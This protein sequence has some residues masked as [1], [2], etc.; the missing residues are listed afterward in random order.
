MK[1]IAKDENN[2]K[3]FSDIAEGDVVMLPAFGATLEEMRELDA[4]NVKVVDTTCPWVA[5]VW[6]TGHTHQVRGLTSIIHG[7]YAHEETIA[8][9]SMC[10]TYICVKNE[11]EAQLVVD[12][13]LLQ[14]DLEAAGTPEAEAQLDEAAAELMKTFQVAASSHFDPKTHL[15]RVGLANQ[16]TMYK[17]ET[18]AIGQM[19]Q[20]TMMKVHGPDKIND[21]Y[22]EFDTICS[23]T[24][25]R[26][27]AVDALCDTHDKVRKS[28]SCERASE[29]VWW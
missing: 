10:E 23:A 26:Q 4:K 14:K 13:M 27:D 7:K 21:H 28:V 25:V 15:K 16:T 6:N 17:K 24:Q 18:R 9:K 22:F 29:L 11:K 19:L 3:D 12:F 20:K 1:F 2:N 8:T 5:K